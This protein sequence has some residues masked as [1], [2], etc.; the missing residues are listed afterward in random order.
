MFPQLL[1]PG[2][3]SLPPGRETGRL[4]GRSG[5]GTA[6]GPVGKREIAAQRRRKISQGALKGGFP[7]GNGVSGGPPEASENRPPET[8]SSGVP[9]AASLL[10]NSRNSSTDALRIPI[11]FNR[12]IGRHLNSLEPPRISDPTSVQSRGARVWCGAGRL[13]PL[14]PNVAVRRTSFVTLDRELFIHI[15]GRVEGKGGNSPE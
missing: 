1:P 6:A 5:N 2:P 12:A 14:K 7:S 4:P 10:A 15:Y 3:T 13:A 8:T 9:F 11:R